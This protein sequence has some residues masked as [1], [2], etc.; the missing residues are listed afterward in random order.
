MIQDA[1]QV[2]NLFV[3]QVIG[4]NQ[5]TQMSLKWVGL[6]ENR[7]R[8]DICRGCDT[9]KLNNRVKTLVLMLMMDLGQEETPYSNLNVPCFHS[10]ETRFGK[11][12]DFL[13]P[14]IPSLSN[15]S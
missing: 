9:F 15:P 12:L 2:E 11:P 7:V 3:L 10:S 8:T 6:D 4:E 13:I 5:D 1:L 14:T